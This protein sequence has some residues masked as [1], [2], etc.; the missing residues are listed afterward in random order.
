MKLLRKI[1]NEEKKSI[2]IIVIPPMRDTTGAH[3]YLLEERYNCIL[4]GYSHD[5]CLSVLLWNQSL[6]KVTLSSFS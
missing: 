6:S 2:D 1:E 4:F 3:D 5:R